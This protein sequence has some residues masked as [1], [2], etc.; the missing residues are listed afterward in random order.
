MISWLVFGPVSRQYIM[1]GVVGGEAYSIVCPGC[2]KRERLESHIPLQGHNPNVLKYP[3]R[4]CGLLGDI[5]EE[6]SF[7]VLCPFLVWL[8]IF[9]LLSCMDY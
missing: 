6:M 1:A 2:K 5:L 9:L 7:Q 8:Y 3:T 4:K